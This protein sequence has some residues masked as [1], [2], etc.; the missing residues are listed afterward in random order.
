MKWRV[1]LGGAIASDPLEK[2]RRL[3]RWLLY[4]QLET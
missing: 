4:R 2:P 3:R 1:G